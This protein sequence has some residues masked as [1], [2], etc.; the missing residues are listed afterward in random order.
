MGK[1]SVFIAPSPRSRER[2]RRFSNAARR[3][4]SILFLTIAGLSVAALFSALR[5]TR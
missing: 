5:H 1:F 4:S 2:G 3:I